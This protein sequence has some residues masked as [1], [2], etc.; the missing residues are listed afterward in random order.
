MLDGEARRIHME[1]IHNRCDELT[2]KYAWQGLRPFLQCV[3][4]LP[5][6]V[7][8]CELRLENKNGQACWLQSVE[9][10]AYHILLGQTRKCKCL[11]T[12]KRKELRHAAYAP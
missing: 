3:G 7:S 4:L 1:P 6:V 9:M 12:F 2:Q 10:K 5:K 8:V 11:Q